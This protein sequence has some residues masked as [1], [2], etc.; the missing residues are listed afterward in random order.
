MGICDDRVAIVTGA[1]RGFCAGA[2]AAALDVLARATGSPDR[3][4]EHNNKS[5]WLHVREAA[6]LD[7]TPLPV[8]IREEGR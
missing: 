4:A 7:G 2:D 5:S 6:R 1:G 3:F 8:T